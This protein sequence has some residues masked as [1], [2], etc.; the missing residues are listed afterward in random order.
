VVHRD[1][2]PG[3]LLRDASGVV[4][5]ADLG[6]AQLEAADLGAGEGAASTKSGAV[7][8]TVDYMAPEQAASAGDVD[9][10]ADIYSLGCT[11]FYVLTGRPVFVG[12]TMVARLVAHR[13]EPP[14]SLRAFRSDASELLDAIFQRMVAKSP[15]GR[16][17]SMREVMENLDLL[18]RPADAARPAWNP[19]TSTVLLAEPSKFQANIIQDYL[20][21]IGINDV[22]AF[23]SGQEV[24]DALAELPADVILTTMQLADMTG[25]ELAQRLRHDLPWMPLGIVLMTSSEVGSEN[26]AAVERLVI[27]QLLIKPFDQSQLA[28]ALENASASQGASVRMAGLESLRVLL[29]DDSSM[30]RLRLQRV[31]ETLGFVH[32]VAAS[33]G[34]EAAAHLQAERF[35]LVLT[36]YHMPNMS[37]KQ[38][39]AHIRQSSSHSDVPVVVVTTEYDPLKLAEVH[40]LG[41]SAICHKSSDP[42]LLRNIIMRVLA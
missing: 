16:Y 13:D 14:P 8:G 20:Q 5:V 42:Q 7:A 36:D 21:Q 18:L 34:V 1:I 22:Y 32:F 6:L 37:G 10:R 9:H 31:L 35:Q 25:I 33:D 23:R 40:Q 19:A 3:N 11:L 41:A 24:I 39:I 15:L 27:S 17:A 29:V 38:L 4:K 28:E 26:M 30:W 2:K 12:P